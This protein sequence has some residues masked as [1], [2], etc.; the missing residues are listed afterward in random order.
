MPSIRKLIA[1]LLQLSER[2]NAETLI[3]LGTSLIKASA[4]LGAF[5]AAFDE[6]PVPSAQEIRASAYRRQPAVTAALAVA[7]AYEDHSSLL[8]GEQALTA[9]S[10]F[11][12]WIEPVWGS[13]GGA[14]GA[15]DLWW[16]DAFAY[17][18]DSDTFTLDD[19]VQSALAQIQHASE[20]GLLSLF[21]FM[22]NVSGIAGGR[23]L[24]YGAPRCRAAVKARPDLQDVHLL[25]SKISTWR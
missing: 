3:P 4:D 14:V 23:S 10:M 24:V 8:R 20:P 15:A 22:S 11:W 19:I 2:E 21:D 25:L 9:Y 7:Y 1:E 18:L 16:E 17:L 5:L 12:R 13:Y 6:R